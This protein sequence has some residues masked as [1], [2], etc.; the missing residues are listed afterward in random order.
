MRTKHLSVLTHIRNKGEV[1]TVKHV[2]PSSNFLSDRSNSVL[3]LWILF[4]I[5][6]SGHTVLSVP[7]SLVVTCL[8]RADL[9]ALLYVMFSCFCHFPILCPGSGVVFDCMDS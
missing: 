1:S 7:C 9:M 3:P 8:K 2:K 4:V 5:C 6:I